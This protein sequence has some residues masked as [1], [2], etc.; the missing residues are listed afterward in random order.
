MTRWNS[1]SSKKQLQ[2]YDC[3]Y[4]AEK[5]CQN[6]YN[7]KFN[8]SVGSNKTCIRSFTKG[9]LINHHLEC[10]KL[11][12]ELGEI[13][14]ERNNYQCAM[15]FLCANKIMYHKHELARLHDE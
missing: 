9:Q 11:W 12:N 2:P 6:A 3:Y 14:D 10:I 7:K 8:A 13:T 15:A 1:S 5:A 4:K